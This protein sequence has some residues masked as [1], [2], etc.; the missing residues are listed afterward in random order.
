MA[1]LMTSFYTGVSGLHSA[2]ASLNTTSHNLAN[3]Q[4]KGY[5]RQQVLLSDAFYVKSM[6]AGG[7]EMLTGK[8]TLI[9]Q[10]RQIRND[11]LDYQYRVQNGRLGFYDKNKETAVQIEDMM[12]ELN[13][14]QFQAAI[15]ELKEAISSLA[16][17]PGNIVYKD[18]M[19]SIASQFAERAKV[20]QDDLN[21]YQTSLDTEIK[22]EVD[23][24][25]DIVYKIKD[26]NKKIMKYEATGESANDYRDQ[27][28]KLLDD[29]SKIIDFDTNEEK[30][31]TITIFAQGQFLLDTTNQYRLTAVAIG[32]YDRNGQEYPVDDPDNRNPGSTLLKVKWENGGDF[33][34]SDTIEY[35]SA[36]KTDVG[37][38]K[39]LMVARGGHAAKYVD[40]NVGSKPEIAAYL[41]EI[42]GQYADQDAAVAAYNMDM[43]LYDERL[44]EYNSY[45][46]PSIVMTVQIQ[47]DTLVHGI[48]TMVNDT[49]SPNIYATNDGK[50]T[51]TANYTLYNSDGSAATV[52]AGDDV[53]MAG[54]VIRDRAGNPVQIFDYEHAFM[55]DDKNDTMG[56]EIFSRRGMERYTKTDY[57]YKGT[58]GNL[59]PVWV[60]NDE[61]TAPPTADK[62]VEG[63]PPTEVTYKTWL[64][65]GKT[66]TK[67]E[68]EM[69]DGEKEIWQY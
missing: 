50:S 20:L 66:V 45:I 65:N 29:L 51:G 34:A 16:S 10:T 4:T 59:Y 17:D 43:K 22:Q 49:L 55:G 28:N 67:K 19:I 1:N 24:I 26:L 12:G 42:G 58:D 31:G 7:N 68:S 9:Q 3:A 14:E 32:R 44:A 39:G 11:F 62:I 40:N 21:N 54:N 60:Y 33:F 27:R 61:V 46:D 52:P 69:S 5:V 13:G 35:N 56:A 37:S 23:E 6:G 57:F 36:N 64:V 38:L 2:Q 8:G 15:S 63:T 53:F 47:L 30:D 41:K 25:N 18:Q 48:V